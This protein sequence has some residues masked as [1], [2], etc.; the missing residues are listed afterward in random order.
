MPSGSFGMLWSYKLHTTMIA[1]IVTMNIVFA[2]AVHVAA[3]MLHL[4]S[5]TMTNLSSLSFGSPA[6]LG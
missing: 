4:A 6:G 5:A 3:F 1:V 2:I